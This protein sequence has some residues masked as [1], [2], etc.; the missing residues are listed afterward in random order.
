MKPRVIPLRFMVDLSILIA[1]VI[2]RLDVNLTRAL[3]VTRSSRVQTRDD[4]GKDSHSEA[5]K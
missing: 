5:R 3:L 2:A 1:K 4:E